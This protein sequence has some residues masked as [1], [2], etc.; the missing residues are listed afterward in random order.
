MRMSGPM[1]RAMELFRAQQHLLALGA[2]DKQP[3][4]LSNEERIAIC[5]CAGIPLKFEPGD[6]D[7]KLKISAE[8][9]VAIAKERGKWKIYVRESPGNKKD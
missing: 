4:Q 9:P 8:R 1:N 7:G 5:F 3:E 2:V 6:I